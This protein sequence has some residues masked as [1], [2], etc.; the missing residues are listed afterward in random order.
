MIVGAAWCLYRS[1]LHSIAMS[2]KHRK[3]LALITGITGQD[4]VLLAELLLGKAYRVI[5]F[6]RRASILKR[7]DLRSL[8]RRVEP[9][10]GDLLDSVGIADAVQ[11]Y[12]PD[13]IY[14]LASQSAPGLSWARSLMGMS[15]SAGKTTWFLIRVL[16]APPKPGQPS[17]MR[18]RPN[19]SWGGA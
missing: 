4:G 14:N 6:G 7:G 18:P 3:K 12:Q 13:E 15:A 19:W 8:F 16:C 2:N 5:G 1:K 17:P 10:H 9:F 11:H